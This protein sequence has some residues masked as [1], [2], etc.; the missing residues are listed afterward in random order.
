MIVVEIK[1]GIKLVIVVVMDVDVVVGRK[2]ELEGTSVSVVV[3]E[4][5]CGLRV[6]AVVVGVVVVDVFNGC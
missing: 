5:R 4:M 3:D 2:V 6:E 1:C